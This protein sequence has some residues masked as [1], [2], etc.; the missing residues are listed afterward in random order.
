MRE[1]KKEAMSKM[2][3]Q[4]SWPSLSPPL[5]AD[6]PNKFVGVA[7]LDPFSLY[8]APMDL[9]LENEQNGR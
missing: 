3:G 6:I 8:F 5:C 2:G 1:V 7:L 9:T 4:A